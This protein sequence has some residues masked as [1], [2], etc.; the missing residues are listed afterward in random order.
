MV[1][2]LMK[3]G[4]NH[5]IRNKKY[6]NANDIA[7]NNNLS[8]VI[9]TIENNKGKLFH[10]ISKHILFL[11]LLSCTILFKGMMLISLYCRECFYEP[12]PIKDSNST[13]LY[14]IS[15]A[16]EAEYIY[17]KA[18]KFSYSFKYVDLNHTVDYISKDNFHCLINGNLT[19]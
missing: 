15:E 1:S 7:V 19:Y 13:K 10:P 2:V 5:N 11:I 12:T 17:E 9:L 16:T 14:S 4:S 6:L 8:S 3:R 18:A